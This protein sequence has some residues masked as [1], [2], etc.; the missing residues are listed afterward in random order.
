M[1]KNQLSV[2]LNWVFFDVF[3]ALM[4][5]RVWVSRKVRKINEYA[6]AAP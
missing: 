3:L 6:G 5:I 4:K 2:A 1:E